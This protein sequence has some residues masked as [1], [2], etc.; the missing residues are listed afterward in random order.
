[1]VN[2]DQ[3]DQFTANTNNVVFDEGASPNNGII[4]IQGSSTSFNAHN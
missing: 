4:T 3:T 2:N 1:M